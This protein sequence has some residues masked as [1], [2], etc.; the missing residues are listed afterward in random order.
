MINI[1]LDTNIIVS[2][3]FSSEGNPA[4]IVKLVA[5]NENMQIYYSA[6]ILEEYKYVR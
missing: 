6:A 4:K 2:A 5:N 1:V 3:A